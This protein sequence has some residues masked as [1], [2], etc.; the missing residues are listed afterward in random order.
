MEATNIGGGNRRARDDN[1]DDDM[2]GPGRASGATA[3]AVFSYIGSAVPR[4]AEARLWC[5]HGIVVR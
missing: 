5:A 2:I 3:H 4:R 1:D